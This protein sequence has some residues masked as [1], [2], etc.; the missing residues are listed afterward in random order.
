[1]TKSKKT[2]VFLGR[3]NQGKGRFT[4]SKGLESSKQFWC[5][6]DLAWGREREGKS[7]IFYS[8]CLPV[9]HQHLL[10]IRPRQKSADLETCRG[11]LPYHLESSRKR[12]KTR[13]QGIQGMGWLNQLT[14]WRQKHYSLQTPVKWMSYS[15]VLKFDLKWLPQAQW[16][17]ANWG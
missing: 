4:R 17:I 12:V 13:S 5:T 8:P 3:I 7:L 1:M 10:L 16:L 2:S 14:H 9:S 6:A 15:K 11:Q